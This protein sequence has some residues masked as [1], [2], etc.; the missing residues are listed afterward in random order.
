MIISR[1]MGREGISNGQDTMRRRALV[2]ASAACALVVAAIAPVALTAGPAFAGT[3]GRAI[4]AAA[5]PTWTIK[6]GG[7]IEADLPKE[8]TATLTD[9]D[10]STTFTCSESLVKG[11]LVRAPEGIAGPKIG[12]AEEITLGKDNCTI[13]TGGPKYKIT[14]ILP[15]AGAAIDATGYTAPTTTGTIN[16][17]QI[18]VAAPTCTTVTID[19]PSG[20][21]SGKL[22]FTF[23]NVNQLLGLTSGNLRV[24]AP[25]T[26]GC[27]GFK[28][29]QAI[30]L[31][32]SLDLTPKQEISRS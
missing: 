26:V 1:S 23:G 28:A 19:G 21:R 8:A 14:V 25:A 17:V 31:S 27:G 24:T 15:K 18:T 29:D 4:P 32:D 16:D 6:P 7:A 30:T 3:P 13:T 2:A 5:E 22:G 10:A 20:A 12:T 11:T 9:A